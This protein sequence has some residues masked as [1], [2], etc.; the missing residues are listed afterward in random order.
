MRTSKRLAGAIREQARALGFDDWDTGE[1]GG[2]EADVRASHILRLSKNLR[3][4]AQRV[5]FADVLAHAR[6]IVAF[7][8]DRPT[9]WRT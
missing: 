9:D 4:A 6:A 1:I 2:L 5:N 7:I 3:D 8:E